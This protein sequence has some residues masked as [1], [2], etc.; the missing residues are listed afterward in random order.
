MM[1][2]RKKKRKLSLLDWIIYIVLVGIVCSF[3][4]IY[5]FNKILGPGLIECAENEMRRLTVL[6]MNNSSNKYL[7]EYS[8]NHLLDISRDENHKIEMISYD[9]KVINEITNNVIDILE[10][11]LHYMVKGDFEKLDFQLKNVTDNYYEML[12]DGVLFTVSMGSATG[13]R[14]LS[15][16]GPKIPLNLSIVGDVMAEVETDITEYG[17]NNAMVEVYIQIEVNTVIHMP[18]LSKK[19]K[20][21][22]KVPL[23]MEMIQG[24]MPSY[25]YSMNE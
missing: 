4:F 22:N 15:N 1:K 23:V 10:R 3:L 20:I 9:T 5:Y 25:Y 6:V 14:L 19:V 24:E 11:D 18:F 16:L 2:N 8:V 13:N 17:L 7:K 21:E 12:N